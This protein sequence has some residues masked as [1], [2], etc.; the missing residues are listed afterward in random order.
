MTTVVEQAG[1][2]YPAEDY[3]QKYYLQKH[4]RLLADL[5]MRYPRFTDLVASTAAA[6]LNGYLG[7]FG[8]RKQFQGDLGLLGLSHAAQNRLVEIVTTD[9]QGFS[10]LTCPAPPRP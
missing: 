6:R 10:G 2:F 5:Q 8:A 4:D 3:H 9:C 1:A 7:C